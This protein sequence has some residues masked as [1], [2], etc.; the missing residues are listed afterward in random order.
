M[1]PKNSQPKF[2]GLAS[3]GTRLKVSNLHFD[4]TQDSLKEI[5]S[6]YGNLHSCS[7]VWDRQDRSTG[8]AFVIFENP[9][10]ANQAIKALNGSKKIVRSISFY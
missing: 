10:G 5:F 9:S 2:S 4:I 8:E 7:I 3:G 1:L 6:K